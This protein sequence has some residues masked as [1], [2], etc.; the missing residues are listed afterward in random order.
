MAI[1]FNFETQPKPNKKGTHPIY[2]RITKST[3]QGKQHKRVKTSIELRQLAHWNAKA[4]EIRKS[5]PSHQIWNDILD[6]E[7]Q[8]IKTIY[9]QLREQN[10]ATLNKIAEAYK[11]KDNNISHSFIKYAEADTQRLYDIGEYN[12]Y[13]RNLTFL[14]KLK[15][16]INGKPPKV[17]IHTKDKKQQEELSKLNK[18]LLFSEIDA[19]LLRKFETYLSKIPNQ[20]NKKLRLHTNTIAKQ[21]S[22]FS[23][24][25]NRG[26]KDNRLQEEIQKLISQLSPAQAAALIE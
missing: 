21:L 10:K 26:V 4:K 22:R 20:R 24:I 7:M 23:S 13:K 25:Y 14:I 16:F 6:K 8:S 17:A 3:P 12:S 1:T 2:I 19:D 18:D 9:R 5:E 11:D 15:F